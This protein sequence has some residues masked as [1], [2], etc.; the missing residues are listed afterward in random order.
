MGQANAHRNATPRV[1]ASS[2]VNT[3]MAY[4]VEAACGVDAYGRSLILLEHDVKV[5]VCVCGV[6]W[7]GLLWCA[8]AVLAVEPRVAVLSSPLYIFG[9][10]HGN[11]RDLHFFSDNLWSFGV[12]L[13]AGGFLF[14]GD[15][16]DRGPNG[17]EVIA[18]LLALKVCPLCCM[19]H[20][21]A[22]S[23]LGRSF[24]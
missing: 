22:R 21:R 5:R 14:L 9:D 2:V 15:Y 7:C 17:I 4:C 20:P 8:A 23:A 24:D 6:L 19:R 11:M 3:C 12:P 16:V 13:T 10:I 1:E 18:Y